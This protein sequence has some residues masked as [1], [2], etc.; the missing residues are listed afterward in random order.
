MA[1][2]MYEKCLAL[3]PRQGDARRNLVLARGYAQPAGPGQSGAFA[4]FLPLAW[5]YSRF[6]AHEWIAAFDVLYAASALFAVLWLLTRGAALRL[7]SRRLA[8]VGFVLAIATAAFALPRYVDTQ[9]RRYGVVVEKGAVVRSGPGP[10]EP[11]YFQA[12]EGE[13]FRIEDAQSLGWVRVVRPFDGR[14]GYLPES[15]AR[16]I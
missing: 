3:A 13:R 7:W 15:V 16:A 8:A 4:L 10:S 1:A 14:V 6:T 12:R 2:W 9:W 11:E 5:L